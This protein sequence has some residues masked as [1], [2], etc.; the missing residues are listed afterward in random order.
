MSD[1]INRMEVNTT[2]GRF[3]GDS[4]GL[5]ALEKHSKRCDMLLLSL[6]VDNNI[7]T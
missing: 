1:K 3:D 4:G 5:E 6:G 7:I 2:L